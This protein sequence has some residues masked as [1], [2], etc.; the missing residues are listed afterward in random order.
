MT[1]DDRTI[2]LDDKYNER[3]GT[4][5]ISGFQALV[6]LP[7]LQRELDQRA[8]LDTAGFISGYRG[9]PIGRYDAALWQAQAHLDDHGII[10]QPGVNEDLAATAVWGTQ[11][12]KMLPDP[13]VD[14]VFS[15]WY[16]KGPGV[17]RSGDAM[18]HGNYAGT[19]P[20][21]G[22]LVIYG[23]DHPGKSSTLAHQSDLALAANSIP[24]LYPASVQEYIEF[25]LLGWALS[26]Y[27]G[28][29]VGFKTVNETIEQTATIDIA[30]DDFEV[31]LPDRGDTPPDALYILDGNFPL[32]LKTETDIVQ[33]RLPLVHRF[34]RANGIDRI[35][36]D[37][38]DRTLGIVT[39]GKAFQDVMEALRL[40]GID[41]GR[42]AALGLSVYK[43]G[44][45]WPL[46]PEGLKAFAAGQTEL[47]FLEEKRAVLEDQATSILYHAPDRPR[48]VGKRDE[49]GRDLV[50]S[51]SMLEPVD[52]AFII[53][54]RLRRLGADDG[55]LTVSSAALETRVGGTLP[56]APLARTP[57]FC[58]GCPHN[59]STRV[60]EGSVASAGIGCHGMALLSRPDTMTCTQMGGEGAHWTGLGRF[61]ET[62]HIF[63]NLGDGTYFHSGLLAIRA[64]VAAGSNI[65][66]KILYNDAVAMTGGQ[67]VDGPISVGR[68][69]HQVVHE[70]V[71]TCVV[72]TDDPARHGRDSDLAAGVKV[73][74]RDRL[75]MVQRRLRETPGCT[76]LIYDQTCAAENRRRR[77]RGLADDPTRRVFINTDVCEG[78]GD[79]S[80]QSNCVSVLPLETADGQKRR[81]DQSSCNK[82][83]S[84]VKGSC[85]SFV[86]VYGGGLRKP[87]TPELD[88][89][90][91]EE[92][93][94][95]VSAPVD[96]TY[97]VMIAGIGGTGVITVGAL[98]GMAAHLEGKGC[99]VYD[100]TG[101]SQK[102]GAVYSHLRFADRPDRIGSPRL[103]PGDADLLIGLDLVA[104]LGEES[105]QTAAADHTHI[106]GNSSVA[107]TAEFHLN[108]APTADDSL[109]VRLIRDRVG[110][111]RADILDATGLAL[112]LIGDTIGVN[113][114]VIG[115]A[116]QKGLLP[117]AIESIEKAVEL[118]GV[119]VEMNLRAMQLGR[120][121]AH[122]P[123]RLEAY[124]H[125]R[126]GSD[127]P[128]ASLDDARDRGVA[129][130]TTY[131]N[132]SYAARFT[133]TVDA[134]AAA[135]TSV[136]P[137]SESLAAAVAR[138]LARLMAY[139]DEYEVARLYTEAPFM[140]RLNEEFEGDIRIKFNLA[141]PLTARRHPDT[142]LP[143]KREYGGW[144]RGLFQI[145]RRL[146][147]LRGTVFDIFGY[148]AERRLERQLIEVYKKL[149]RT[150][151]DGLTPEN[152]PVAIELAELAWE[153][154]GFGHVKER[155]I[156]NVKRRERE[157]L[158]E[159]QQRST[160]VRTAQEN[161]R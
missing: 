90:L 33:H 92:L 99:S 144:I 122:E 59:I 36:L 66:F 63:Q 80:E 128:P 88:A 121:Y 86:T 131:Q 1:K 110:D 108:T 48:I 22:V 134:V 81:I 10:F 136:I 158:A 78:C 8:G 43:V 20:N 132:E 25:G 140:A 18:K 41:R 7:L 119:A 127:S 16:G 135:E 152:H 130:L 160:T 102:N 4:V 89:D 105:I 64:A 65:T 15:I 56:T 76:V 147:G 97:G 151:I 55:G 54:D 5:F 149:T 161:A 150:L 70:G 37:S 68:I 26:R 73:F 35:T 141:P 112:A 58:S 146:K 126:V 19:H 129:L 42:A 157:L 138:N 30:M 21:G 145:L 100:M 32:P 52:L 123:S 12:L 91:F 124:L 9:S 156:D 154:R 116:A 103:G 85:P 71:R 3:N 95:P 104:A 67:P 111:E 94:T 29:W 50:S 27:A 74:H 109:L 148:A 93:P 38:P 106:I 87:E 62:G 96:D 83:Y 45:V 101:L 49:E 23:D 6:L 118:N 107:P 34:V 133:S 155:T 17:D 84:C 125:A 113:L 47:L 143:V 77:K 11:Q 117:V 24:S 75:D 120:L 153:I 51:V 137:G 139:K 61:T 14:G 82:D 159:F 57:F 98:L 142:G 79:C 44:C 115:Y 13:N 69:S 2:G 46:D 31:A 39:A 40:L 114:F 28:L 72:V 60:P 53:A